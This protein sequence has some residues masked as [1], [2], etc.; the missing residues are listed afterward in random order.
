MQSV[1]FLE[2]PSEEFAQK[3]AIK[4]FRTNVQFC[5]TDMRVIM[6]T[7]TFPGEGKSNTSLNLARSIAELGKR[8]IYVDCD[9]RKSVVLNKFSADSKIYGLTHFLTGMQSLENCICETDVK[10]LHILWH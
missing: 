10:N 7:S 1:V 8:T 6:L 2:K 3:E 5:G 9:L 4:N